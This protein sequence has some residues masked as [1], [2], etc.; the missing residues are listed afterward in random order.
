RGRNAIATGGDAGTPGGAAPASRQ[1][2]ESERQ[3]QAEQRPTTRPDGG[4]GGRGGNRPFGS[5]VYGGPGSIAPNEPDVA[6][7]AHFLGFNGLGSFIDEP[8]IGGA[9]I[10]RNRMRLREGPGAIDAEHIAG[11]SMGIHSTL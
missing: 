1:S 6:Q 10:F 2:S 11:L 7:K 4:G 8:G 9:Q 5:F 3:Q